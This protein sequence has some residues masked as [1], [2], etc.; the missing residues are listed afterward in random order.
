MG[1]GLVFLLGYLALSGR[2]GGLATM[3]GEAWLW[4][5]ITGVL[6]AGYVGTWFAA[7]RHAPATVVTSVLVAAAPVTGVLAA[8]SRGEAPDGGVIAGY[9]LVALAV[10]LVV[11]AA[12][13]R[14]ERIRVDR[15]AADA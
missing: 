10:A 5:L 15:A 14:R 4:V 11:V 2:L 13:G 12:T 8:A 9:L 6:L 7:L 1:L 3:S